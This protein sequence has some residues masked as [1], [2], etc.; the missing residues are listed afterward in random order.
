M[1]R[2][3][4]LPSWSDPAT[5][6]RALTWS[7]CFNPHLAFPGRI[8]SAFDWW[9]SAVWQAVQRLPGDQVVIVDELQDW[10][11]PGRIPPGLSRLIQSGRA[12]RCHVVCLAQSCNEVTARLRGQFTEAVAFRCLDQ[13][14][15]MWLTYYGYDPRAVQALPPL[16]FIHRNLSNGAEQCGRI[17]FSAGRAVIRPAALAQEPAAA[18][19]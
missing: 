13:R 4:G 7:Q 11:R 10:V 8:E 16:H 19:R 18:A 17:E 2:R 5:A 12:W 9:T 15:L 6:A 3:Y 1:S 14:A